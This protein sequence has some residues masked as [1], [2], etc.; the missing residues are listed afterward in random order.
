MSANSRFVIAT[1]ILTLLASSDEALA[2]PLLAGSIGV[3]PVTVR[4][5]V[6]SLRDYGLVETV[7]GSSGGAILARS[8]AHLTLR[9]VYLCVR[10]GTFFGNFP[11]KPNPDCIVGRNVQNILENIFDETERQM[12]APLA[13]IT[14]S[15]LVEQ[16]KQREAVV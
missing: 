5:V 2:S 3:N 4:K 15:D 6:M 12:I 8:A 7:I 10:E 9:D 1:H 14:I 16:V 11:E 13:D